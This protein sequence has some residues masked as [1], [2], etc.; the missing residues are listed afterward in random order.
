VALLID[1]GYPRSEYYHPQR[2]MGTLMCHYRHRAHPDPFRLV[3]LQDITAH[4]DFSA[5]AEAAEA[6][7]LALGGYT[8]QA[9]F[10]LGCGLDRLVAESDPGDSGAHL[11]VVQE[12][13]HL[14]LPTAMGE[15]FKVIGLTRG[16]GEPLAG[17]GLRDL[18]DRL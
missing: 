7:G 13:R 9:F 1:Y 17:F 11:Q 18:R 5:V 2:S 16:F 3:G 15:S 12:V 4:V 14:T 10:L 6:A 8:T